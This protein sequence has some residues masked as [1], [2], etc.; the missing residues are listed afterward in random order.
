MRH[1]HNAEIWSAHRGDLGMYRSH[2]EC[3]V[4]YIKIMLHV[5]DL[6]FVE[7]FQVERMKL[8]VAVQ[9]YRYKILNRADSSCRLS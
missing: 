4:I 8:N 5:K 7:F 6:C 1:K 9:I 3:V 2:M